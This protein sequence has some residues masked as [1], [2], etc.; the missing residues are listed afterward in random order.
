MQDGLGSFVTFMVIVGAGANVDS[1]AGPWSSSMGGAEAEDRPPLASD[2]FDIAAR[3]DTMGRAARSFS[4]VVGLRLSK[5]NL[6][7]EATPRLRRRSG[8]TW[9][10]RS[11]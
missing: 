4:E 6:S 11:L 2:L 3:P 10:R 5:D 9:F 1:V 7:L 8:C